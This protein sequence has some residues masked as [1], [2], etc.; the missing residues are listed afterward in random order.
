MAQISIIKKSD[1]LEAKR[2]DAEYFKPEYLEL[3]NEIT[4]YGFTPFAIYIDYLTDYTSNGSFASLHANV[5]VTDEVN[6]AKWIRINELDKNMFSTCR[7]VDESSYN[8]LQKTKLFG[9]ELLISKTGEY[10]GKAFIVPDLDTKAT[11]ADNIFLIRLK[12]SISKEFI[13]VFIN[14]NVGQSYIKRLSQGV[15]QP[16]IIK[17]SLRKIRIPNYN[18]PFQLHIEQ[19]VKSSNQKQIL[20]K[21]LYQEAENILLRELDLLRYKPKHQLAFDVTN[22]EI[23][24]AKRIDAEYFQPKYKDIIKRIE[25][26]S[27]GPDIVG[28]IFKWKKG[29]EVG[30]DE[31]SEKGKGFVR[32]SDFTKYGIENVEKK[33]SDNLF[34]SIKD[35]F[36][37]QK[38]E[39]LFTKDGTIGISYVLKE[40]IDGILSGAFLRLTLKKQYKDYEKEC[41]ALILNS[42]LCKMQIEKLSGGAIIAHLKPSD[43]ENI[44]LPIIKTQIQK[45]ISEKLLES[46]K[47]RNESKTLLEEAKRKVEKEIEKESKI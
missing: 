20:S 2:F 7:Y 25:N 19:I 30:A 43:F 6:F 37:P 15:G 27:G 34:D 18:K 32:V 31:Y 28:N 44:K 22:N 39:I 5:R 45:Q 12:N 42:L 16:T 24:Q 11:L 23:N 4:S 10:L 3:D 47:L 36:Q 41:L 8:Y 1:I 17:D 29:I 21:Q 13:K 40:N 46:H 38:G 33:I 26:Y 14:S 9:G 35:D